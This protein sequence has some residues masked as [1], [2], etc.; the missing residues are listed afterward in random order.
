[1]RILTSIEFPLH[2]VSEPVPHGQDV[3][4]LV[5]AMRSLLTTAE[6]PGG[7]GIGLAA[8]QV[9]VLKRVIVICIPGSLDQEFINPV[10]T[11][12]YGGK[13]TAREGCLSWPTLNMPKE[14]DRKIVVEGYDREWRPIMKRLVGLAARAVQHEV[15]HLDGIT[16][17]DA[18]TRTA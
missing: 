13:E 18:A 5:D 14:R 8:N 2:Q 10:I 16:I 1:M 7:R 4:E 17:A 3:A 11:Q 12:R 6:V 9:G 15:D